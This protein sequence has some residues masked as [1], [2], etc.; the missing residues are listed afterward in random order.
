M[1]ELTVLNIL[2]E[3]IDVPV[4]MEIPETPPATFV[5]LEKTGSSR[6]DYVDSAT[7]AAQSY[8]PTLQEAAELNQVVKAAFF[9]E[10]MAS[11]SIGAVRLN[12]DYNF[13]NTAT[14]KYRY[15]A[16]FVVTYVE[17]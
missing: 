13:T 10:V 17:V 2:K 7:F 16:V 14:K 1:I 8:A 4:Y 12:S 11:D 9:D 6:R 3:A 5:V 15:Q